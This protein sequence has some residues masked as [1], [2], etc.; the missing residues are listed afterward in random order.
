LDLTVT[1]GVVRAAFFKSMA[2]PASIA[3]GSILCE[4]I[5]G[6]GVASVY[7]L[8]ASDIV[9]LLGG[10]PEGKGHCAA[11]A[12]SALKDAL[13]LETQYMNVGEK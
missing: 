1:D 2:C 3:C 8:D 11:L 6:R 9:K 13:Q 12:T 7:A 4:I 5:V 10:L